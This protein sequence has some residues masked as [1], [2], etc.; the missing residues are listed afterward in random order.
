MMNASPTLK[1]VPRPVLL[2]GLGG[3]IPFIAGGLGVWT[4]DLDLADAALYYMTIYAA[5]I[6]S[7]MGAIH[8][9]LALSE[10]ARGR[11]EKEALTWARLGLAVLPA[12]FCWIG[13]L[14]HPLP[15]LI[16]IILCFAGIYFADLNAIR[17]GLLPPWY[18]PLRKLLTSIVIVMLGSALIRVIQAGTA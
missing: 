12:I 3:L 9:G 8:W 14:A 4:P 1:D 15:G 16:L 10:V 18:K 5:V 13:A 17:A 11:A 6:A 7:F 2:L